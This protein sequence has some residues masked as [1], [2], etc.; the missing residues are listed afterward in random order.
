MITYG[1]SIGEAERRIFEKDTGATGYECAP[2][3]TAFSFKFM[4]E[5]SEELDLRKGTYSAASRGRARCLVTILRQQNVPA[6]VDFA[7]GRFRSH[8][9]YVVTWGA[10]DDT[11]RP[12]RQ[13]AV[14]GLSALG[15]TVEPQCELD[16]GLLEAMLALARDWDAGT[17]SASGAGR[18]TSRC[19][20]PQTSPGCGQLDLV[21]ARSGRSGQ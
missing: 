15:I 19:A 1:E 2:G 9:R 14:A 4:N 17:P 7:V 21:M 3:G 10:E 5:R 8:N 20:L 6:H 12:S 13:A 18:L 11:A 16:T